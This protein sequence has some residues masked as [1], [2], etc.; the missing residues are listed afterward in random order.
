MPEDDATRKGRGPSC[1]VV[2]I[3]YVRCARESAT[4]G[5]SPCSMRTDD[6]WDSKEA[7]HVPSERFDTCAT[8]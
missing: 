5:F 7:L 2:R 3:L 8:V 1:A 4:S 6:N